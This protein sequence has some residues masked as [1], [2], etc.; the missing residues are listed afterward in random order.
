M[1]V[2]SAKPSAMLGAEAQQILSKPPRSLWADAW[3]R[4]KRN[5]AAM[6]SLVFIAILS[7]IAIFAPIIAPHNPLEQDT[8]N[9]FRQAAWVKTD[10]KDTGSWEWLLG[11]DNLGRDV[12]SRLIYGTRVSLTVGLV[13]M[14]IV[15][16]IGML[17]GLISGYA[18]GNTDNFIM[19]G[20]D[21]L[22]AF[23]DLLLFI[24]MTATLRDTPLGR[25]W[26]GLLL[27]FIV[28]S[29]LGWGGVARLVRGQVLSLK[30]KEFVEAARCV[31]AS[32][33]RILTTHL[34]P[35]VLSP[36]IVAAAFIVP[37]A[38]ITEAILGY[39]GLG[40]RPAVNLDA[41]FPTSWGSMINEGNSALSNQPAM[42]AAPAL[43]VAL[44]F[45]AF[46]FLG[47]GLRDALDPRMKQ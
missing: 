36:V 4:L 47:D 37:G 8:T 40:V 38:I 27:L 45:M 6:V 32:T 33:W 30:E 44:V 5:K 20:I 11:T 21:I 3:L 34:M 10:S 19:R 24:L 18:G 28:L 35:N 43:A 14:A 42:M 1:A 9:S 41:P 23:P 29:I 46:T 31:G 22:L 16:S 25:A 15:V 17:V 13:P 7:F 39:L 26:N 2:T 12:W